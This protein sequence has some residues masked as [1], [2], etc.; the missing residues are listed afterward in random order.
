MGERRLRRRRARA[1]CRRAA[2]RRPRASPRACARL[3]RSIAANSAVASAGSCARDPAS[4]RR[5]D[6]AEAAVE[7]RRR[8][9]ATSR[10]RSAATSS[11]ARSSRAS[12]SS[13]VRARS[14]SAASPRART[15]PADAPDRRRDSRE[16]GGGGDVE[17]DHEVE[18]RER[19]GDQQAEQRVAAVQLRA[20]RVGE[21][22]RGGEQDAAADVLAADERQVDHEAGERGT[23]GGERG[24]AP[25]QERDRDEEEERHRGPV[26]QQVA[27][28]DRGLL[29]RPRVPSVRSRTFSTIR[30]TPSTLRTERDRDVAPA[31]PRPRGDHHVHPLHSW[32]TTRRMRLVRCPP[33]SPAGMNRAPARHPA[34]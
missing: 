10:A 21:Q 18:D 9:R 7:Q 34:G 32:S 12:R 5:R 6:L 29:V 20:R 26:R 3:S 14:S 4:A 17:L 15:T 28:V 25:P 16:H 31:D 2:R 22:E 13:I 11:R 30:N 27:D 19:A 33:S 23:G 24:D 8:A 1:A